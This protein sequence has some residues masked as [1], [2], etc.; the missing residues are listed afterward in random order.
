MTLTRISPSSSS[1]VIEETLI[2]YRVEIK[3]RRAFQL[4]AMA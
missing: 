2:H 1:Q 3:K 4:A